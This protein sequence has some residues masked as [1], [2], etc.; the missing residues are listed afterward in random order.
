MTGIQPIRTE[1]LV[2]AS[3]R[4]IKLMKQTL[5]LGNII[6]MDEKRPFAKAA[7]IRNGVFSYIGDAEEAK[8]LADRD[9]Q[10][11]DYSENYI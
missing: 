1:A 10:V 8:Q 11:L 6:T 5:I 2:I 3:R 4:R 9:V 7:L